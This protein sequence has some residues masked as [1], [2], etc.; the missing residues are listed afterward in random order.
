MACSAE[1]GC[2]G[3]EEEWRADELADVRVDL[4]DSPLRDADAAPRDVQGLRER[5]ASHRS[6]QRAH[7]DLGALARAEALER[8]AVEA[9]SVPQWWLREDLRAFDHIHPNSEGHALISAL[10]CPSLPESWGCACPAP[11]DV[12]RMEEVPSEVATP[13][14]PRARSVTPSEA[15]GAERSFPDLPAPE[16]TFAPRP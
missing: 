9:A 3:A 16:S 4:Y 7:K 14:A 8:D 11:V 13:I 5:F 10:M 1:A 6:W 2:G 15:H 12:E